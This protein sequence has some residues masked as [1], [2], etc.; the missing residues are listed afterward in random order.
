MTDTTSASTGYHRLAGEP[1]PPGP[2]AGD[3]APRYSWV[4][5]DSDD[6]PW[7]LL[8]YRWTDRAAALDTEEHWLH[9]HA[10]ARTVEVVGDGWREVQPHP[11]LA[12]FL[13]ARVDEQT[14]DR[15]DLVAKYHRLV[16]EHLARHVCDDDGQW[17]PAARRCPWATSFVSMWRDHPEYDPAWARP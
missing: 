9:H 7:I 14:P 1:L 11:K 15:P 4:V 3:D 13:H 17:Y 5:R 6:E 8:G 12:A 16:D 2:I 10:Q